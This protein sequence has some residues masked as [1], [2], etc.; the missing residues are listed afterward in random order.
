MYLYL[1]QH[2]KHQKL[3]T[4]ILPLRLPAPSLPIAVFF[5]YSY[6]SFCAWLDSVT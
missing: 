5:L 3:T 1:M 4:Y 2:S 6:I